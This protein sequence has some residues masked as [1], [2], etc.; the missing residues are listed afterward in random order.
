M[1]PDLT[2]LLLFQLS[3]EVLAR[4]LGLP[5]PGPVIGMGLLLGLLLARPAMADRLRDTASGLLGHLSLLFVPAGVGIVGHLGLLEQAGGAI[6]LA[7]A[8]STIVAIATGAAVFVAVAR[9]AGTPDA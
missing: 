5:L 8:G 6:L 7:L 1:I 4:A 9:L 3:G 2:M